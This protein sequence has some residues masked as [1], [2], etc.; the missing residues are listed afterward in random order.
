MKNGKITAKSNAARAKNTRGKKSGFI[1][2]K[3]ETDDTSL[4]VSKKEDDSLQAMHSKIQH[5]LDEDASPEMQ[6]QT[7]ENTEAVQS[8]GLDENVQKAEDQEM[9]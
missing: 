8:Q 7:E 5:K 4:P 2:K 1:S 9:A 3:A 6:T